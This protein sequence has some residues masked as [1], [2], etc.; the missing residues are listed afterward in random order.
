MTPIAIY[1]TIYLQFRNWAAFYITSRIDFPLASEG[2][3]KA[4]RRCFVHDMLLGSET[5]VSTV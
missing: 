2:F 3:H 1:F 4:H 5:G